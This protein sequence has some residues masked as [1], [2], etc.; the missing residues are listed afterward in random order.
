MFNR[1]RHTLGMAYIPF[2]FFAFLARLVLAYH[3][4]NTGIFNERSTQRERSIYS[5][6]LIKRML[7]SQAVMQ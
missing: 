6:C 3:K 2:A 4:I 1:K 5:A 7:L